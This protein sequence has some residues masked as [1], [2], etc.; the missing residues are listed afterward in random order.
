M[1]AAMGNK[2]RFLLDSG[3]FTAWRL[4]KQ[5]TLDD[6]CRFLEGLPTRPWRYFALDEI[7]NPDGTRRNYELMLRR[8]FKPLPVYTRGAPIEDLEALY[9][10]TD[11][12]GIG[13]L[14][15]KHQHPAGYLKFLWPKLK[16]RPVHLLGYTPPE[17]LKI[18]RP[19]SCDSSSWLSGRQYGATNLY[20]GNGRFKGLSRKDFA[21]LPSEAICQR[22]RHY[23]FDPADFA[24][25]SAWYGKKSL[26]FQLSVTS[27]VAFALDVE[28][29][30]G[31]K[32]FLAGTSLGDLRALMEAYTVLC[33]TTE[34]T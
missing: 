27:W 12:V 15:T 23:G 13:G 1:L 22:I 14:V 5:I 31:T 21:P 25:D 10:T 4:G 8:G 17:W 33:S 2:A 29:H 19:Y 24:S 30:L 32:L 20:L 18:F 7:G 34:K 26:F 3:A 11:V 9:E 28:K 6:Y 16:G